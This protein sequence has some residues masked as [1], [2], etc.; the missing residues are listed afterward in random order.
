MPVL[1]SCV[2]RIVA[3]ESPCPTSSIPVERAALQIHVYQPTETDASEEFSSSG[4]GEGEEVMA[5][6]VC[7]LPSRMWDGLWESL[8]FEDD[9]KL[10][11][12]DYIYATVLFS[13]AN[14][15]CKPLHLQSIHGCL[16]Q[17]Q[18]I[19]SHGIV[20]CSCT[21]LQEQAKLSWLEQ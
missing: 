13:D 1:S 17:V 10:N 6:S 9:T 20:S 11:L 14:V 19:S 18:S 3:C 16:T 8:I 15:D 5:A 7:E 4:G 2:E 21:A 12:L